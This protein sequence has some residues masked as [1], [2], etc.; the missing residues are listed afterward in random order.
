MKKNLKCF[1]FITPNFFHYYLSIRLQHP[2][3]D[4]S[5]PTIVYNAYLII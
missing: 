3:R 4:K 1:E 5:K 2:K